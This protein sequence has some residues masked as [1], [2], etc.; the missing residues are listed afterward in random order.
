MVEIDPD[1]DTYFSIDTDDSMIP[2]S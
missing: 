1:A 2:V